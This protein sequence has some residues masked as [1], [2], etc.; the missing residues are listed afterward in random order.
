MAIITEKQ[1]RAAFAAL[2]Q[3]AEA[4]YP[5]AYVRQVR[6]EAARLRLH[7]SKEHLRSR[8]SKDSIQGWYRI[9]KEA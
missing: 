2:D 3:A 5:P 6:R 8:I 7:W 9:K 1:V 4:S